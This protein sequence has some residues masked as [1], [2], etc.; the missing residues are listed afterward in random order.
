MRKGLFSG[1]PVFSSES[2]DFRCNR[3]LTV[4]HHRTLFNIIHIM[5]TIVLTDGHQWRPDLNLHQSPD[6]QSSSSG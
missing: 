5:R 4:R 2:P 3:Q 1:D 6:G